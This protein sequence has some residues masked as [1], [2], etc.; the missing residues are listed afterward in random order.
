MSKQRKLEGLSLGLKNQTGRVELPK[1]PLI[2]LV[3]GAGFE[4]A[5]LGL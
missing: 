3:G 4:P 2:L 5:T 1:K